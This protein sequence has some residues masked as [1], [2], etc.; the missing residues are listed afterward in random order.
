MKIPFNKPFVAGREQEY[1]SDVFRRGH[2]AGGGY[3]SQKCESLLGK[4]LGVPHV[5]LT[6]SCTDALEMAAILLGPDPGDEVITP[7]FTFV[8]TINAFVL[9]GMRPVFADILPD[10]LNLDPDAVERLA[11]ERTR[12]VL[13]V[14]YAGVGC[15]MERLDEIAGRHGLKVVEDNAHGV[16]AKYRDR[17]LGTFGDLATLSFHETKNFSCGEG[18]ALLINRPDYIERA[19]IIHDK[20]TNRK[21]FAQGK[22]DKYSWVDIGSSF[23][24]SDILAACLLAQLEA[25]DDIQARRRRIW[26]YYAKNLREWATCNGVSLPGVP[27]HCEQSYHMFYMILPTQAAR[28]GLMSHLRE[29]EILSVFH[30]QPL[31]LSA[32]G[33]KYGG[34]PGDCPVTEDVSGRLLRLPFYN[35]LTQSDQA[36]VVESVNAFVP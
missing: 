5:L 8:S 20:G 28:D 32:M 6:S 2:A 29:K 17:Y 7:S 4:L 15:E 19:D 35:D 12:A 21:Q 13:P 10:T 16:F 9:R 30:Y 33:R 24:P 22:I 27:E 36:L 25:R 14:H 11:T 23:L 34:K 18:G 3:Y 1:I 31:H 26:D